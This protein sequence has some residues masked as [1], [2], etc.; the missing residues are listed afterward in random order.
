MVA[1]RCEAEKKNAKVANAQASRRGS[2]RLGSLSDYLSA[3]SGYA[4]LWPAS[5]QAFEVR[6]CGRGSEQVAIPA[7]PFKAA[8]STLI[9]IDFIRSLGTAD[10]VCEAFEFRERRLSGISGRAAH[11]FRPTLQQRLRCQSDQPMHPQRNALKKPG[12]REVQGRSSSESDCSAPP[13]GRAIFITDWLTL[14]ILESGFDQ[15]LS[16][17][18]KTTVDRQYSNSINLHLLSA[19]RRGFEFLRQEFQLRR[20]AP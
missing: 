8:Y 9:C 6:L 11:G 17:P 10:Y 19:A 4:R 2:K 1:S 20:R 15:S 7:M 18:K 5:G 12:H 14:S 16:H 3:R 13:K